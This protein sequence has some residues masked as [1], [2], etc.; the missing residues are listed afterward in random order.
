MDRYIRAILGEALAYGLEAGIINGTG[1][2]MPIGMNRQVGTGVTVTDGVYPV[3][4]PVVITSFDPVTYG[5]LAATL[6]TSPTGKRRV[7]REILLVCNP[8]VYLTKIMPAT[9]IRAADGKYV[10][11]VFPLPTRVVQSTEISQG[12]IILGLAKRYFMGV[13]TAKSGKV[14]YSD[15]YHFLEDERVYLVKLYGYGEPLDNNAFIVGDISGLKP[16][17][18]E[19]YVTNDTLNVI[20]VADA[21]LASLSIGSLTLSPA[22]NK[23]VFVYETT[24]ANATNTINAQAMDG[25]ATIEILNGSTPVTNG[26]AATWSA[27]ENTVTINVTAGTETETYTIKVTKTA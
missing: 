14:E 11:N 13:G 1:K 8:V 6:A 3:K 18:H 27:G 23:S 2:E 4:T 25:E 7:V 20:G 26:A 12:K 16:A 17:V 10:N 22:F 19:V 9:T 5:A 15:E 21:R 24:T